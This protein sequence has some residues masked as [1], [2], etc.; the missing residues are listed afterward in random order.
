MTGNLTSDTAHR[1]INDGQLNVTDLFRHAGISHPVMQELRAMAMRRAEAKPGLFTHPK[2]RVDEASE[3][4][5]HKAATAGA[6][7]DPMEIVSREIKLHSLPRV[8]IELQRAIDNPA[9]SAEDLARIISLDPGLSVY[10]LR[11]A[12][13]AL[14]SFPSRIDTVSRAVALLGTRQVSVLALGVSV[15]KSYN[16]RPVQLLNMEHFWRHSIACAILARAIAARSGRKDG[17]R[18]FV[19]GLLHDLGRLAIF[20][21]IPDLAREVLELAEAEHLQV[22]QAERK[23]LGF[24][25]ARLGAILLRKWN[26]PL[27]LALAV[28]HHHEPSRG[29][30]RGEAAV[31]HLADILSKALGYGGTPVFFVQPLDSGV[32]ES[33]GLAAEDLAGLEADLDARFD[34]TLAMLGW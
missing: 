16:Q 19:A 13:S 15:L 3:A 14:Y 28:L 1:M 24:D 33:L 34:E 22:V 7:V 5:R 8:I 10:L 29:E 12:N 2:P 32:W 21:A 18:Y 17:E 6:G 26:F 23:V 20:E 9:S 11:I 31:V 27:N 4:L 30:P 25:H